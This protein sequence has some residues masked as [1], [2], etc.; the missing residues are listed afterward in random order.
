MKGKIRPNHIAKNSFELIIVGILAPKLS[1]IE[2]GDISDVL[3]VVDLPDRTRAS[4]GNKQAGDFTILIP[5]HHDIEIAA[6]E[7]W[8]KEAQSP[9]SAV[10]KKTGV[11]NKKTLDG[12]VRRSYALT[13]AFI[14]E[15]NMTTVS[16]ENEGEMD[17]VE[18]KINFD[19]ITPI[20]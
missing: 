18:F 19:D 13:G 2:V 8:F 9:V 3:D 11:F 10:Y 14:S 6:C 16:L 12:K 5:S 15:R 1:P 4:G 20:K 7:A 17:A